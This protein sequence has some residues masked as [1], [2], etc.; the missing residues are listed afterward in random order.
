MFYDGCTVVNITLANAP[1]V[2]ILLVG[3]P[4]GQ[5]LNLDHTTI[6]APANKSIGGSKIGVHGVVTTNS[7]VYIDDSIIHTSG[8][9]VFVH[10][11]LGNQSRAYLGSFNTTFADGTTGITM[12][13]QDGVLWQFLIL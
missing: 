8:E 11:T 13:M 12:L 4:V 6:H 3:Q 1:G 2:H 9:G 5:Y 10:D 7:T